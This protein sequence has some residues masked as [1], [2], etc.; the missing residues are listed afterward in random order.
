MVR[1]SP[2][3]RSRSGGGLQALRRF[4]VPEP[5]DAQVATASVQSSII[6]L[7]PGVCQP[8]GALRVGEDLRPGSD[9]SAPSSP[10]PRR[11]SESTADR[12][13]TA[14]P[15]GVGVG[16]LRVPDGCRRPR[17]RRTP[18]GTP[19]NGPLTRPAVR[20]IHGGHVAV[21]VGT[22]AQHPYRSETG[23]PGDPWSRRVERF[24]TDA[25]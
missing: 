10:V 14:G 20:H 24:S 23:C 17:A 18:P 19:T 6:F 5:S 2:A 3:P 15:V 11:S 1:S 12:V 9:A 21:A 13:A 22:D 4:S 25:R 8:Q 16:H 7:Q